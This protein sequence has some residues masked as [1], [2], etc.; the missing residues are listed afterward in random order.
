[1]AT[2]Q[3]TGRSEDVSMKDMRRTK[4]DLVNELKVLRARLAEAA[5][6]PADVAGPSR[7]DRLD[8]V[9]RLANLGNW[10]MEPGGDRQTW[11]EGTFRIFGLAPEPEA[12]DFEDILA[13]VHPDDRRRYQAAF[14]RALSDSDTGVSLVHRVVTP[15]GAVRHVLTRGEVER[16]AGGQA[17]R[18]TGICRDVTEHALAETV[19]QETERRFSLFMDHLPAAVM[20]KSRGGRL[21]FANQYLRD[22]FGVARTSSRGPL[23]AQGLVDR[24]PGDDREAFRDGVHVREDQVHDV[25]GQPR[26]LHVVRF[27]IPRDDDEPLL[28]GLAWD[29]TESRWLGQNLALRKRELAALRDLATAA[30]TAG[31]PEGILDAAAGCLREAVEPDLIVLEL[32]GGE[33]GVQHRVWLDGDVSESPLAAAGILDVPRARAADTGAPVYV[34][35]PG[36]VF[37]ACAAMPLQHGAETLGTLG[38]AVRREVDLE[39]REPFLATLAG[40]V[41]AAAVNQRLGR[42]I[43]E[44]GERMEDQLAAGTAGLEAVVRTAETLDGELLDRISHELRTPLTSIIGFIGVILQGMAGSLN[45]EQSRQLDMADRSAANLLALVDDVVDLT[46]LQSTDYEPAAE[47]LRLDDLAAAAVAAVADAAET[48][49]R[50]LVIERPDDLPTARGDARRVRK[51]LDELLDNAL[52]HADAGSVTVTCTAAAGRVE[53]RVADSG[54]GVPAADRERIFQPFQGAGSDAGTRG[55]GTGLGLH[56]SRRVAELMG[57]RLELEAAS[58]AGSVF[59][60]GLPTEEGS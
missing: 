20:I 22:T 26:W 29:V 1:M 27:A 30:D 28:G 16:V 56:L 33:D 46:R 36:D 35:G 31:S 14:N 5:S 52:T 58:G 2:V 42:R 37:A 3:S 50:E 53:V 34:C 12:V 18:L 39:A 51:I 8:R 7:D 6:G 25:A 57:G 24:R 45:E 32:D 23:H 11:T 38:L 13:C 49:G 59:V 44:M 9:E 48:H 54:P 4:A 19:L 40:K 15:G 41:A 55:E 21:L 60:L 17:R 43:R 10:T 47:P